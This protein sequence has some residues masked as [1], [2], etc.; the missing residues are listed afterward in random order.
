[1]AIE[2]GHQRQTYYGALDIGKGTFLMQPYPKANA[3][4]TVDFIRYLQQQRSRAKVID[5]FGMG[6]PIITNRPCAIFYKRFMPIYRPQEWKIDCTTI[7]TLYAAR[8]SGRR[9]LVK[10]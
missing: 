5:S 8:K 1:M 10:R 9:P 2:N 3:H 6:S 4:H 7:G